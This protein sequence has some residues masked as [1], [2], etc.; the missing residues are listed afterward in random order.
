MGVDLSKS[1]QPARDA[2][3]SHAVEF[4]VTT[5]KAFTIGK[6]DSFFTWL[7]IEPRPSIDIV[8]PQVIAVYEDIPGIEFEL[9]DIRVQGISKKYTRDQIMGDGIFYIIGL[10]CEC[11]IKLGQFRQDEVE[12]LGGIVADL[13]PGTEVE[14]QHQLHWSMTLRRRKRS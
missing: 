14:E 11:L 2:A 9:D 4:G 8:S 3:A 12:E 13:V 6:R 5:A 10:S 1:F 7:D